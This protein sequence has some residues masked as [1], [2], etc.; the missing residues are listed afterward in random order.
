MKILYEIKD[1]YLRIGNP[2]KPDVIVYTLP[3]ADEKRE[4]IEA[5]GH[6]THD[7]ESALD[8]DEISRLESNPDELSIIWKR[9]NNVSFKEHLKFE[10]SSVGL[11]LK[12][13][14][15]TVIL[16]D[17]SPAFT[18]KEFQKVLSLN[19]LLLKFF[20]HT[21]HH[22][23]G[24]LRGIKMLTAEL[25]DKL[26]HS[27]EN[28]YLIQMFVLSESLVY[29]LNAIEANTAVLSKL[30]AC[31]VRI[32]FSEEEVERLDDIVIDHQQC[33]RQIQ[34]YSSVM[35]GLMDARAAIINNNMNV[36][37]KN[38]TLI[39]VVFLPMN[40]IAGI[41]GMSEFSRFTDRVDWR[42][43]YALFMLAMTLFGWVTWVIL[44]RINQPAKAVG[45]RKK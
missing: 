1:G 26:Q 39:N 40:L 8:P 25:Q 29:Y 7:L 12:D 33:E 28:Q 4:L 38:L 2:P 31:A 22:Y 19:D 41:G 17:A 35:S 9:P 42:I 32:G 3:D 16:G 30:R 23:L 21:V 24:H 15:L 14:H 5:L 34:I 20:Q 43:S 27:M 18:G 36:L 13:H 44:V 11:F 10:V 37:L 6:D 45:F